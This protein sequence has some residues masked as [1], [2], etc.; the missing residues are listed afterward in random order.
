MLTSVPMAT[1]TSHDDSPTISAIAIRL[2][3]I[4]P[5][6]VAKKRTQPLESRCRSFRLAPKSRHSSPG[7][8]SGTPASPVP[9]DDD[10]AYLGRDCVRDVGLRVRPESCDV[11]AD[12]NRDRRRADG[13]HRKG[14]AVLGEVPAGLVTNQI[15]ERAELL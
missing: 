13:D 6:L 8:A 15:L 2:G 1:Q 14:D 10:L 4:L 11:R 7:D 3:E 12:R 5:F 9:V